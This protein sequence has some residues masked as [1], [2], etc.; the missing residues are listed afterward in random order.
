MRPETPLYWIPGSFASLWTPN[1]S[2]ETAL[3]LAWILRSKL[4]TLQGL[5]GN[6][7]LL[8]MQRYSSTWLTRGWGWKPPYATGQQAVSKVGFTALQFRNR[9]Q[10]S[11][12]IEVAMILQDHVM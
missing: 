2:D 11:K 6:I 1:T 5:F 7:I 9:C 3:T 12:P 8:V 4:V 10:A